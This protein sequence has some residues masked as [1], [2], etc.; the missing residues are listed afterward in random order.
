[1]LTSG[2]RGANLLKST[3]DLGK[4]AAVSANPREDLLDYPGLLGYWLKSRVT[5]PF[6]DRHIAI[7]EWRA[8]HHVERP[9][10]S[11][12]LLASP[13]PLHDLGSLIFGDDA[14]YLQQQIIFRALAEW[15]IQEN[16][17]DTPS[18][19][20]VEKQDLVGVVACQPVW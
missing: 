20:L 5:S 1:L 7:S 13:T 15:P 8:R 16:D 14:L 19:P 9:T 4:A 11:G 10:L 2:G 3:A 12:M 18:L 6:A 17:F